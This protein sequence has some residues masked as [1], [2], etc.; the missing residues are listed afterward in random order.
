MTSTGL[1]LRQDVLKRIIDRGIRVCPAVSPH[2]A[3]LP[4]LF[5]EER[6][7][8]MFA[9]VRQMADAGVQLIAG[10]DAGVQR[11]GFDGLVLTL[12]FYSHLGLPNRTIIEMATSQVAVALGLAEATGRIAPGLR[13]DLLLVDGDPHAELDALTRAKAVFAAGRRQEL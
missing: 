6:A 1:D 2:W 7:N 13:G 12:S 10:T 11:A 8:A 4:K 5:G 9:L 3:I